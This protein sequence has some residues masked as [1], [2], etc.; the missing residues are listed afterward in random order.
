MHLLT[1]KEAAALLTVS[2]NT[3]TN[4]RYEGK[5]PKFVKFGKH[6]RYHYETLEAFVAASTHAHTSNYARLALT[7]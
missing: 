3:L 4:W 2:A 5:G 7:A 6:V 1:T